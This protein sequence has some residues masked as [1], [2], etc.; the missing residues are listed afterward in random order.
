MRQRARLP[1]GGS[2]HSEPRMAST[3]RMV[4]WYCEIFCQPYP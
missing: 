4:E 2:S 3:A 1:G